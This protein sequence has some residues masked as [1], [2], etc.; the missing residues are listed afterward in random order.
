M[1]LWLA[2]GCARC[3]KNPQVA[4]VPVPVRQKNRYLFP[5]C[6][7]KK[8]KIPSGFLD[9]RHAVYVEDEVALVALSSLEKLA[10]QCKSARF[11]DANW[12][13]LATQSVGVTLKNQRFVMGGAARQALDIVFTESLAQD[14]LYGPD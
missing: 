7:E 14:F 12:E 6:R 11:N 9:G 4:A 3:A 13:Y 2:A 10:V 8:L 5:L 1:R